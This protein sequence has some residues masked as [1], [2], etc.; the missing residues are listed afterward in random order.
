MRSLEHGGRHCVEP[1]KLEA[2]ARRLTNV[3][4][5]VRQTTH[6][7]ETIAEIVGPLGDHDSRIG[8]QRVGVHRAHEDRMRRRVGPG[9]LP[10]RARSKGRPQAG[11]KQHLANG[12]AIEALQDTWCVRGEGFFFFS[13]GDEPRPIAARVAPRG[14]LPPPHRIRER[15][16]SHRGFV[17]RSGAA[18]Q[19]R[20]DRRPRQ[21]VAVADHGSRVRPGL[22][23]PPGSRPRC[24]APARQRSEC[25]ILFE[26]GRASETAET[27][28]SQ[29]GGPWPSALFDR[30]ARPTHRVP[31]R[32]SQQGDG[33]TLVPA[34]LEARAAEST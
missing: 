23:T 24:V 17:C 10:E 8:G 7:G 12:L 18:A 25:S 30:T 11:A 3:H 28:Q 4:L 6:H 26:H 33:F 5:A 16:T 1:R 9:D 34:S 22:P 31:G 19:E 14:E 2:R 20:R 32:P 21:G 29:H 27:T 15:C 13:V